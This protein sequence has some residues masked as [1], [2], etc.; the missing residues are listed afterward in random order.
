MNEQRKQ[1]LF[2][3][4]DAASPSGSEEPAARIWRAEAER[5]ADEVRVDVNGSSH[6][7]LRGK[8]PVVVIEGH[9]D[10]IGLMITHIDD[11]GYLWFRPIGGWDDQMLTGQR[12][13]LTGRAGITTG[14]IGRS[15]IHLLSEEER[16]RAAR[17]KDLWIDIGAKGGDEARERVAVGDVAVIEQP[18][19]EL[20]ND[21][22][23]ARG[24]DNRAGSYVALETLRLL[25]AD[26]PT[27][28][29]YAVAA[30]QEEISHL[31]ARTSAYALKPTVAIVIDVTH[32]TDAPGGDK[33]GEGDHRIGG[34]PVLARGSSVHPLVFNRLAEAAQA[35]DIPYS[36]EA[37]PRQTWTDADAFSP[38][39]SGIPT[40]LVSIP[41]RYMHSPN[42]QV[43]LDDLD[44]AARL[45]A[46]FV[47]GLGADPDFSRR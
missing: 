45:I 20:L 38:S 1:F 9:I 21:R 26:R 43:S 47:R 19:I 30:T 8:G 31:G 16:G 44:A 6:A 14:V 18:P 22:M 29:V 42:E 39:R 2:N 24:I 4:L 25:A 46:A 28:D 33:R 40:G 17:I 35:N 41:N 23:I 37:A 27:A 36:V 5:F 34:G 13:R 11:Q 7:R 10:E 12:V 3:L 32:A 15:P